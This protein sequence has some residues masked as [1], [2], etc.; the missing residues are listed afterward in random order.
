MKTQLAAL[1]A[2]LTFLPCAFAEED[3]QV[4]PEIHTI[5]KNHCYDCHDG[6]TQEGDVNLYEFSELARDARLELLNR[7]EE[8]VYLSQMPPE[9]MEQPTAAEREQLL[10]WI[11]QSFD[12][13]GAKS[14]FREK[15]HEPQFGNYVDHEKLF[16]GEIKEKPFSPSRRWLI[17]P[18]IFESKVVAILGGKQ[19]DVEIMNPMHL[20]DVSGVRDYDNKLAGGDHFITMLANAKAI[21]DHQL[22]I[23]SPEKFKAAAAKRA[24]LLSKI[25]DYERRRPT[26]PRLAQYRNSLAKLDDEIEKA[27]KG[28][29]IDGPFRAI[30]SKSTPPGDWEMKVA[31]H[32][33]YALVYARKP[34]PTEMAG[35]LDLM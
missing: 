35:C 7:M 15:L 23:I 20:P 13:L 26:D 4:A 5:L 17:S 14:E 33:Q 6:D 22:G 29:R 28:V 18:Y 2:L 30:T 11:S 9:E 16:S 27:K 34:N 3:L 1:I 32:H 10:A 19:K 8:Q 21:T 12:S 25:V 24:N 31:I